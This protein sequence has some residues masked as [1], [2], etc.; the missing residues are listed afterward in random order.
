MRYLTS[1]SYSIILDDCILFGKATTMKAK[2]IKEIL[3][4]Y[5]LCS[6]QCVNF[7]KS[8]MFFSTNTSEVDR[9]LVMKLLGGEELER[10]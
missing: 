4:T 9:Y 8:T 2:K 6:S 7:E 10:Y 1:V 3:S 5:E